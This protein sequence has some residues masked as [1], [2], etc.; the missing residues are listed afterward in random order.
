SPTRRP[1]R[2]GVRESVRNLRVH[3]A[4]ESG[5]ITILVA[6]LI[7]FCILMMSLG[8]T[9]GD[10]W[11]HK[12]HLQ[13]QVDAAALAAAQD[14]SFPCTTLQPAM[15]SRVAEY[16]GTRNAQV[17]GTQSNVQL[18]VNSPTYP[19]Q[20]T[21]DDTPAADPCSSMMVDVK[22]TETGLAGP[23]GVGFIPTINAHARVEIFKAQSLE[24]LLP[25]AVPEPAPRQI[26]AVFIDE[27]DGTEI[28]HVDLAQTGKDGSGNP[29]WDNAS[30]PRAV[31]VAA[32]SRIGVRLV[33]TGSTSFTCGDPLVDC[34]DGTS[35]NGL[36][37]IRGWAGVAPVTLGADPKVRGVTL[38]ST[39]CDDPYFSRPNASCN[40]A[41]HADIDFGGVG[42]P[43]TAANMATVRVANLQMGGADVLLHYCATGASGCDIGL[44]N[45]AEVIPVAAGTGPVNI[46]LDWAET[47]N[48]MTGPARSCKNTAFK[49]SNPCQGSFGNV[50]RSFAGDDTSSGPLQ[51]VQVLEDDVA[52]AN[53]LRQCDATNGACTYPLVVRLS[54]KGSLKP[55]T[56][57]TD[58]PTQIRITDK[59]QTQAL[60]CDPDLNTIEL[61]LAKGCGPLYTVNS[62]RPCGKKNVEQSPWPNQTA[63]WECVAI[64]TGGKPPQIADG[65]NTRVLGSASATTCTGPNRFKADFGH[66]SHSDPRVVQLITTPFGTFTGSGTD[67]TF[68]VTNFATFYITGWGGNGGHNNPCETTAIP[69]DPNLHDDAPA[70]PGYVVGHFISYVE[71]LPAGGSPSTDHCDPAVVTTCVAVLTR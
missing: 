60:D 66:W 63:P 69:A 8:L 28:T 67:D 10:W 48:S 3:L 38:S 41:V 42:N 62:G 35:G 16:G 68:P 24:G 56:S 30:T 43:E 4:S 55:A 26:R 61:E 50:Q 58:P 47:A 53:S 39:S 2:T 20:A 32:H 71:P 59:N 65:F 34:Y 45:S 64:S 21:S 37:F 23:I 14:F 5:A 31:T 51:L 12:R 18:A 9:A 6:L 52:G 11:V 15:E 46:G 44:W 22:A 36:V 54:I 1:S 70:G 29:I 17:E 49:N 57:A 13:T 19:G 27:A 40:V 33:L 25:L 7:P